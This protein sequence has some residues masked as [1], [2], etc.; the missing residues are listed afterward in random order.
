MT[1]SWK[2]ILNHLPLANNANPPGW[3]ATEGG[4]SVEWW[5]ASGVDVGGWCPEVCLPCFFLQ[6]SNGFLDFQKR[7]S[8]VLFRQKKLTL[9]G[10]IRKYR[11]LMDFVFLNHWWQNLMSDA[12]SVY[13][14][15]LYT[16][17]AK[18][19]MGL[20]FST[21]WLCFGQRGPTNFF[22]GLRCF[23]AWSCQHTW[24]ISLR[25]GCYWGGRARSCGAPWLDFFLGKLSSWRFTEVPKQEAIWIRWLRLQHLRQS[26]PMFACTRYGRH[27]KPTSEPKSTATL[28]P[29]PLHNHSE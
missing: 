9:D 12:W 5:R 20:I 4:L 8:M 14:Y 13:I 6:T 25:K 28:S 18:S 2:E 26:V 21:H 29:N 24:W 7:S 16:V 17:Y 22:G 11:I 10:R 15:I 1:W 3:G 19:C 23:D 27:S